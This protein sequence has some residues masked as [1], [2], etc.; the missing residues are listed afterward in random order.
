MC[1][2]DRIKQKTEASKPNFGVGTGSVGW[3]MNGNF[4]D[5]KGT[6]FNLST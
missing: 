4:W 1:A 2:R 3:L 6:I 5:W